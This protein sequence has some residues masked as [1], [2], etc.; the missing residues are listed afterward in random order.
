[1]KKTLL[2]V[3]I[4]GFK[5]GDDTFGNFPAHLRAITSHVLPN[6][7]IVAV[8]Y[9]KLQNIVIDIEVSNHTPSPTVDPSVHV[10]LIGHSMGGM[11][12]AETINLLAS[13]QLLPSTKSSSSAAETQQCHDRIQPNTFMFPHIQG[14]LAFDT[15]FLGISPGTVSYTAEN[16]YKTASAAYG[17]ISEVANVF[18][19]KASNT[20][21][22]TSTST[23]ATARPQGPGNNPPSLPAPATTHDAAATPSWQRWG[24]YA[25]FA[26]AAGAVAAGGAAALYTQRDRF[27]EG[28]TW[29]TSHLEFVGC[30]ARPEELR[31]RL[32]GIT[33]LRR[34][35]GLGCANIYTRLGRGAVTVPS[36]VTGEKGD[37]GQRFSISRHILRS[38]VRTFCN[39]P[40]DVEGGEEEE[41]T[42]GGESKEMGM[43]WI[44]AV[45]DRAADETKAHMTM[46]LPPDNSGFYEMAHR[47]RDLVAAWVDKG[48][49]STTGVWDN[50]SGNKEQGAAG[51]DLV[52]DDVA[53]L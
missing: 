38:K 34:E 29:A 4:H 46:F 30:L 11:V 13:E 44:E 47:A 1:M 53:I 27:L 19:W 14:L 45:N 36:D 16:H 3:F 32:A 2:L 24:R 20:N 49:Y 21:T 9:P 10:I 23:A 8:T 39:L 7:D 31:R 48:W 37:G 25:M 6:I 18:G 26:G 35:R 41:R 42:R 52:S 22:S 40:R 5:G 15:P 17:A 33:Q 51:G 28:W 43:E 12:G 50:G